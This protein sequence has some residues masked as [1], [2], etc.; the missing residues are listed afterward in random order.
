MKKTINSKAI[1]TLLAK[2]VL[3][4][5]ETNGEEK[6]EENMKIRNSF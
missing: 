5:E 4:L 2:I 3:I 1:E 6:R